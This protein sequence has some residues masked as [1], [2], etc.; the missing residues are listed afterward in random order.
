MVHFQGTSYK[1]HTVRGPPLQNPGRSFANLFLENKIKKHKA[2]EIFDA[3]ENS[4][5]SLASRR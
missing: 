4:C 2:V 1:S 3:A 5:Y